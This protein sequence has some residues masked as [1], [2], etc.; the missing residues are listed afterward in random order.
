MVLAKNLKFL[1]E[2]F[3]FKIGLGNLFDHVRHRKQGFVDHKNDIRAKSKNLHF[4]RRLT[5]G[6]GLKF[7]I[8]SQ[9]VFL[10]KRLRYNVPLSS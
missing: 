7:E 8:F 6:F 9:F 3:F 10:L 2:L 4:P 1:L 5:H